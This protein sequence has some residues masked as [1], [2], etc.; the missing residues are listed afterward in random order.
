MNPEEGALRPQIMDRF[1]LRILVRGLPEAED[2]IKAYQRVV[3]YRNSPRA[4]IT[5]Y[6]AETILARTEL[7][8]AHELLPKVTLTP[9]AAKYGA[10]LISKLGI[11]SLR[12]EV[13][14][15]EAARAFAA[16]DARTEVTPDDIKVVA[17][18]SL[19]M[20]RS[21]YMN[22]YFQNQSVEDSEFT[23]IMGGEKI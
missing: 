19:R 2:R 22:D 1:G 14:L 15:F 11:D 23:E 12:A 7:Q 10:K 6:G 9:K 18:I 13:T 20:R 8:Q 16:S 21:K 4:L 17:S 3:A 5:Q